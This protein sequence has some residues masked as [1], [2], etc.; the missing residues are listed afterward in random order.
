MLRQ[1]SLSFIAL[2]L[3]STA[4]YTVGQ[5][6]GSF[7][8][9]GNTL[10][11]A[12]MMFMG[13]EEKMYILDKA[14]GNAAQVKG[15]PAWG[16]VWDFN[17]HQVEVMD[18]RTNVFCS[19]G[20]HL[21]NGSY[22][23]LGGNGAVGIGGNIGSQFDPT[24]GTGAWDSVYQDFDGG[25]SIRVLNPCRSGDNFN[26]PSCQWFDDPTVLAMQS[27]RWYSTAEALQDGS[28]IIIGGFA[29]GGYINRN[30]PNVDPQF[31]GG[32][33]VCTYEFFP[34]K[35]QT[36]QTFN[37]LVQTSGLNAYP[38]T[39]LMPSGKLFVQANVSTVLWDA[40]ANIETPLPPMPGNVV[41]VYPAS[42][43][44]A[45]LPLTPDNQYNPTIIFCGG[46]DMPDY[47]W[48][49]Y[50]WPFI[51]TWDYPASKDCQRI[52][53]EPTDGSTPAYEQDDDMLE[54]RTMG[55]FIILPDLTLLVVNGGLNGTAGY[56][57]MTLTTPTFDQM[58]FGES[59]A[60]GP[61]GQP[62]IYN[63]KAPKGSRWSNAGFDTSQIARLYHSSAMLLPDASVLIAGSNPNIDVNTSTVFP[64]QYQA[65]IL[66][67][68]YF[69]AGN[70][71]A[72]TGMPSKLTYGGNPFDITIPSSSYSGSS[73][74]A[75]NNTM[76]TLIRG[77]FTTH[78]MNMGQRAMQLRNTYTVQSDGTIVLHVAQPP[79]NPYI[80]QP[81]P[82]FLYVVING[83]PSNGTYVIL[84]NGQIGPQ[85]TA[86][87]S[88]LP[89][90]IKADASASGSGQES[91]SSTSATSKTVIIGAVVGGIVL[92]GL[93]GGLIGFFVV[94]RKRASQRKQPSNLEFAMNNSS[95]FGPGAGAGGADND[96]I[97]Q[98]DM[99][100][101]GYP[102]GHGTG[103]MR[104]SDSS[105]FL[106]LKHE[107]P[108]M[109]WGET[110]PN[111]N[112]DGRVSTP[113]FRDS[114][115]TYRGP[116]VPPD[117]P[118]KQPRSYSPAPNHRF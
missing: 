25:R 18:V 49:N 79:P 105:A 19:S 4:T 15:H 35:P 17:T 38:H 91:N 61:V 89:D 85:P 37:F 112:Y 43:A 113:S 50:S 92:I 82:A 58:P 118:S 55:Q 84:G 111:L 57:Q 10:V 98:R 108:S 63:P 46:S 87:D 80:F 24:Q 77:G 30:Y 114:E 48:G 107:N 68:L 52:T 20:M 76:I 106:P 23:T 66:Y 39:F 7:A 72:P 54:G 1:L 14:E 81:G 117:D 99:S 71:P 32:A 102:R 33:A 74:D 73:N 3:A 12:M 56:S 75:A 59:L 62:A 78:A 45:M 42:G 60:S 51:D 41:R 64:T 5:K 6:A 21:P 115:D 109:A 26:D 11:S 90:S 101:A 70:R 27:R 40:N 2:W 47:N 36:P 95:R 88:T 22:I 65:E 53:P 96:G 28:V 8:D 69:S 34:E 104:D 16:S 100:N 9:G 67:P 86:A 13:N 116:Y 103:L 44:V 83:I 94:R 110:P 97:Y 31:E 29:N 93:I